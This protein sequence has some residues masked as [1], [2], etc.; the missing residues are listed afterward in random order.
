MTNAP[1]FKAYEQ[2]RLRCP[3]LPE[4]GGA[5]V[6]PQDFIVE[7]LPAYTPQ[8]S[9][10]HVYVWIE[11]RQLTTPQAIARLARYAGVAS[12]DVGSAGL[13]D[14]H[15]ITRQWLSFAGPKADGLRRY[16]DEDGRLQVLEVTRHGN[17]LR[18]GHLRG[19][20]FIIRLRDVVPDARAKA[21][22][23]LGR[24]EERGLPN[25]YGAQRFGRDGDNAERAWRAL[26]GE[27]RLPRDRQ[28]RRLLVS[29]LQSQ[30]FNEVLDARLRA[31]E[32]ERLLDGDV[33]AKRESGSQFVSEDAATDQR[34]L[35]DDELVIT[36]PICG[37]RMTR[38]REGSEARRRED[39]LLAAL[40]C[41]P[42]DFEVFG[43]IARGGRRPLLVFPEDLTIS[44]VEGDPRSLRIS[45]ALPAGSYA[46][47][48]LRELTLSRSSGPMLG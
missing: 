29:A 1:P 31:G 41:R 7:E 15:A 46:T 13:K 30:L 23:I 42:E 8:G 6:E 34:R 32:T 28:R 27:G 11:K 48:L 26:V 12:R 39:E 21:L 4:T 19:N 43:R 38:P 10:E 37:P 2:T 33:L 20:R 24:L 40:G 35:D 45:F 3:D 9:G 16:D 25:Y 5:V 44:G 17:K 22:P 36:G 47:V 18:T 14:R